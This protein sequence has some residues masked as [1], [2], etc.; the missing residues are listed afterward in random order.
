[1]VCFGGYWGS[2][3]GTPISYLNRPLAI[4]V[5]PTHPNDIHRNLTP[6]IS[7]SNVSRGRPTTKPRGCFVTAADCFSGSDRPATISTQAQEIALVGTERHAGFDLKA[8]LTA[9]GAELRRLHSD[10]L[11]EPIPDRMA[12]LL[13]QLDQ[14]TE[15]SQ[16]TDNA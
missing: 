10:V 14:P 16:D 15:S 1:M 6:T 4:V 3:L 9:I 8:V 11:R 5:Y 2:P 13:K 7:L 12:E